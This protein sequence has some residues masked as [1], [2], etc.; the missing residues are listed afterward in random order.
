MRRSLVFVAIALLTCLS[1]HAQSNKTYVSYRGADTNA[2]SRVLPCRT[3]NHALT[4]TASG[5][6]VD[7]IDS[8]DYDP[9]VV[10]QDVTVAA[11]PGVLASISCTACTAIQVNGGSIVFLKNLHLSSLTVTDPS[12]G[13][14]ISSNTYVFLQNLYIAKFHT[15][16]VFDNGT[17]HIADSTLEVNGYGLSS[18][19]G[20][21]ATF[22][23][24]RFINNQF[25]LFGT[26]GGTWTFEGCNITGSAEGI[27][28]GGS[29]NRTIFLSNSTVNNNAYGIVMNL[30]D[31]ILYTF[32][33]NTFAANTNDLEIFG[34][35]IPIAMK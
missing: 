21:L 31:D 6:T 35:Q 8:G 4:V 23:K 30:T 26:G 9:F 7:I 20:G 33:N 12:A 2:C 22:S 24:T 14:S 29:V 3:V 19:A 11:D 16:V 1:A 15:G 34:K 5:G 25:G 17:L 27:N 13:V 28:H 32:G 10:S 18:S